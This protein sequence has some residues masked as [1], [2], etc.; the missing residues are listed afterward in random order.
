[1]VLK[2][3]FLTHSKRG[4]F[5]SD[6]IQIQADQSSD[7]IKPSDLS[8]IDSAEAAIL[9]QSPRGGRYIIWA[10]LAFMFIAVIWA[11]YAYLDEF[12]RGEGTVI[13]SQKVQ[14]IQN[15]EGG[16]LSELFVSEGMRVKRNQKLL[17]IDDTQFSSSFKEADVT[18]MQLKAR[19]LRLEAETSNQAF[20]QEIATNVASDIFLQ[21]QALYHSRINELNSNKNVLEQQVLQRKQEYA[22]MRSKERQIRTSFTLLKKELDLTRPLAAQGAVSEV[23]VIRLERQLNDLEGELNAATLSLPRIQ[24]GL[25]EAREKLKNVVLVFKREAEQ[26][27]NEAVLELSRLEETSQALE[28]RVDRTLVRSPVAGTVKQLLV[29]TIGG[30]IQPGMDIVEIGPNE[31]KLVVEASLRP[32]EIAYI[33]LGQK[34]LVKFSA[35][36]FSVHGGLE[37][38]V[39]H[40]SPDTIEDEEGESFYTVKV[41]TQRVFAGVDGN[42]LP[43]IP[44]MTVSVDIL[45]GKK[46]VMS[47]LLKPILKTKQLA[48]RER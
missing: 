3:L 13:P 19:V 7:T 47:Y 40:I 38:I 23:E 18:L 42:E 21:Q 41:E 26:E 35:Y 29:T 36:D 22:E 1:M 16:I 8:Y 6:N 9:Q 39:S 2:P 10:S 5:V 15:L 33:L 4:K 14:R 28:D 30:I 20:T 31:E 43:I 25:N 48:L 44:G 37:G 45:T 34:A 27:L 17:R 32:Q 12:A 46:T 11:N 24:A